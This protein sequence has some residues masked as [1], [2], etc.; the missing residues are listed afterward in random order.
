MKILILL[1]IYICIV[2]RTQ[3]NL[4]VF[5]QNYYNENN[6]YIKWIFKN[7]RKIINYL[8]I[9]LLLING[10][11]IVLQN[12]YVIYLNII[13]IIDILISIKKRKN[14][15]IKLPLKYTFRIIRLCFTIFI[16]NIIPFILFIFNH[17]Y[18][19]LIFFLLFREIFLF[20]GSLFSIYYQARS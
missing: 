2:L 16:I 6:R 20:F 12:N 7:R 4:Q 10:L 19:L 8:D 3:D 1:I 15:E 14:V 9:I 18:Y 11:N 17:S 13:Y 5:Q